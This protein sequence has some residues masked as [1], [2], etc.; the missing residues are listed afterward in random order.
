MT[1][2]QFYPNVDH[3]D[4]VAL[5]NL[6]V[7]RCKNLNVKCL[8]VPSYY[9]LAEKDDYKPNFSHVG[10]YL[11]S[12]PDRFVASKHPF[13]IDVKSQ[14]R[15]ETGNIAVEL[16]SLYFNVERCKTG[17]P[18]YYLNS[19]NNEA[20]VFSPLHMKPQTIFIQ[21]KWETNSIFDKYAAGLRLYYETV[22][23]CTIQVRYEPTGGSQDPFVLI[24]IAG[25]D[26]IKLEE[27]IKMRQWT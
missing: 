17:I 7:N 13:L 14:V 25:L 19:I 23:G 1:E 11:R 2:T 16:S 22:L 21:P 3:V 5:E 24:P 6:L 10:L 15:K 20:R 26:S 12:T 4:H 27:F 9:H 18:V 8:T